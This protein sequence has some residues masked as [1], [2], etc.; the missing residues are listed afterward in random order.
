M[1]LTRKPLSA[2]VRRAKEHGESA[3]GRNS[4]LQRFLGKRG[5]IPSR[6]PTADSPHSTGYTASSKAG[7]GQTTDKRCMLFIACKD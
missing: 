2:A 4:V 6:L 1:L 3:A 5:E 7:C